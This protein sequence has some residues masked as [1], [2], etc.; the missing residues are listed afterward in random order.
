VCSDY[1]QGKGR[2][3]GLPTWRTSKTAAIITFTIWALVARLSRVD[4]M[5]LRTDGIVSGSLIKSRSE[6]VARERR[7]ALLSRATQPFVTR[8]EGQGI[9]YE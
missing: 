5:V 7:A 3:A 4:E 9:Q 6:P 1:Y 8:V 2:A